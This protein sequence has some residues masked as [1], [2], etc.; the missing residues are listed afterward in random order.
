VV[1]KAGPGTIAEAASCGAPLL[2]TSYLPG[3]E[4]GNAELVRSAGAGRYTP[5]RSDLQR[6][7]AWLRADPAALAAMRAAAARLG[8]PGAAAAAAALIA[9]LAR[10]SRPA[11]QPAGTAPAS[12]PLSGRGPA[13]AAGTGGRGP[14]EMGGP[15]HGLA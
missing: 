3:Q 8:Q 12:G 4:A 5:R 1:T 11:G 14:A 6:E 13:T 15:R 10:V 2:I 7:I 9:G